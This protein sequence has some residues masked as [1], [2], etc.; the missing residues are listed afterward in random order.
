MKKI[1]FLFLIIS[2]TILKVLAQNP[3]QGKVFDAETK[4]PVENASVY[5]NNTEI[6]M[7]TN[8]IGAF[9]LYP[10]DLYKDL[11]ISA[12]GYE[13][14]IIAVQNS[15]SNYTIFLKPK[16]NNLNQVN[17]TVDKNAWRKW[18]NFFQRLLLG[19]DPRYTANC[20]IL[21]PKDVA[22]YYDKD[23]NSLEVSLKNTLVIR[24]TDLGYNYNIDID[25]FKYSFVNDDLSYRS[26][27][28]YEEIKN[29]GRKN[30]NVQAA[31]NNAYYGSKAHFYKSLYAN[32]LMEEGFTL[33]GYWSV[34]NVE[35]ERVLQIVQKRQAQKMA[36]NSEQAEILKLSDNLDSA[37][38]YK[39]ILEQTDQICWGTKGVNIKE[40]LT[41]DRAKK[42]VLFKFQDTLILTYTRDNELLN[43]FTPS[44]SSSRSHRYALIDHSSMRPSHYNSRYS[45]VSTKMLLIDDK[46]VTIDAAGF[47]Y[48]NVLFMIGDLG[49]R[50][51][52]LELPLNYTPKEGR[53]SY[54][55]IS[56]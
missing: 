27:I 44:N 51:L 19:N 48:E 20:S 24:N 47:T 4:K 31:T 38:Y 29:K 25:E 17:I 12:V 55:V 34:K 53:K 21:N 8:D 37:I 7:K 52:A 10:K 54:D 9:R 36:E 46:G 30:M 3:V 39:Q 41:Y 33:C 28:K 23:D 35:K 1:T 56:F 43:E 14:V 40:L 32:R 50:R 49:N 6:G 42:R 18:G 22:F 13:K 2:T 15:S 11:V 16:D 26:T 5:F 45:E